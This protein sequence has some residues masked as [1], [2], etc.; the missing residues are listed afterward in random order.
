MP[1]V[2]V[3]FCEGGTDRTGKGVWMR[4]N[5]DVFSDISSQEVVAGRAPEATVLMSLEVRLDRPPAPLAK[6]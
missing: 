2:V 4:R 6:W 3:C 5:A 1:E